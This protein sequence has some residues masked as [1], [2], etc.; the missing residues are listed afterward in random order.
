MVDTDHNGRSDLRRVW[1]NIAQGGI[2]NLMVV[3]VL[4]PYDVRASPTPQWSPPWVVIGICGV[5][6]IDA[7]GIDDRLMSVA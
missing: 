4:P 7:H 2:L 3:T 5:I 6:R 1:A